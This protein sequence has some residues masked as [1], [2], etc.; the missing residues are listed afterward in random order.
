MKNESGDGS[1]R[2]VE[3]K[4]TV[5][6]VI[7]TQYPMRSVRVGRMCSEFANALSHLCDGNVLQGNDKRIPDPSGYVRFNFVRR[8]DRP[9]AKTFRIWREHSN[10]TNVVLSGK[11]H[12]TAI[13]AETIPKEYG[14]SLA[15]FIAINDSK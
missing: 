15:G 12:L 5:K 2:C 7:A 3:Q 13:S 8:F 9:Y 10:F 14:E 1:V 6:T 11:S 4:N